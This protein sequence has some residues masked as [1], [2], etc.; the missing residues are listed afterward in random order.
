MF[1]PCIRSSNAKPSEPLCETIPTV[2]AG[3]H[4]GAKLAFME[5]SGAVLMTPMQLGPSMRMPDERTI[6]RK[7]LSTWRPSA[8]TS[9]KP[10][11]ITTTL[12][13]PAR[14]HSLMESSTAAAGTAMRAISNG[15]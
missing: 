12:R 3:G 5:I 14:A 8:E 6:C 2:P 9:P 4:T 7:R 13:T 10:A 15:A 11:E 1:M